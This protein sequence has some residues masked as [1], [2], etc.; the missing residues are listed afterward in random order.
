V[1]SDVVYVDGEYC[2][3]PLQDTAELPFISGTIGGDSSSTWWVASVSTASVLTTN[4]R[5]P[6]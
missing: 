3:L 1:S 2:P 4:M 5:S 6:C